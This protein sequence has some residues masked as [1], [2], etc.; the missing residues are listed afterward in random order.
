MCVRVSVGN[1]EP[2]SKQVYRWAVARVHFIHRK[3]R[4][5]SASYFMNSGFCDRR[6]DHGRKGAATA[7]QTI[8][9]SNEELCRR[10]VSSW[11]L[12]I[13]H[14]KHSFLYETEETNSSLRQPIDHV[15]SSKAQ[16]ETLSHN[17]AQSPL[18]PHFE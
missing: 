14:K 2:H 1:I 18:I 8:L 15:V 7:G 4:A 12:R 5:K 11:Y 17:F 10:V 9:L 13:I 6:S 3:K 16:K